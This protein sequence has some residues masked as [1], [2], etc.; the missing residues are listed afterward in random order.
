[1]ADRSQVELECAASL[2]AL[3]KHPVRYSTAQEWAKHVKKVKATVSDEL[4]SARPN[5]EQDQS[6]TSPRTIQFPPLAFVQSSPLEPPNPSDAEL[7][8]QWRKARNTSPSTTPSR[9]KHST[10]NTVA[11]RPRKPTSGLTEALDEMSAAAPSNSESRETAQNTPPR[12]PMSEIQS[13][14][15]SP[16]SSYH[17]FQCGL[18]SN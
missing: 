12:N 13:A 2:V 16:L 11:T 10:A 1:M 5:G 14:S 3:Q 15:S 18:S 4:K 9:P 17:E 8:N 6:E 7:N